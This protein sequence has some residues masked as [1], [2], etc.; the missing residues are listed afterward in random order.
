M[1]R[2]LKFE[3][4]LEAVL[5]GSQQ[6]RLQMLMV[7]RIVDPANQLLVI[8]ENRVFFKLY[9][10]TEYYKSGNISGNC[11]AISVIMFHYFVL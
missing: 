5:F 8:H 9:K 7:V 10:R 4:S 1:K 6:R 2:F 11:H 3:I